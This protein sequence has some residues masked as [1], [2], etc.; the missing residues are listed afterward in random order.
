[1]TEENRRQEVRHKIK[2]NVAVVTSE[3]QSASAVATEISTDGM[4][5]ETAKVMLP[6]TQVAIFLQLQDEIQLRGTIMWTLGYLAKGLTMYQIGIKTE[7][8][9]RPD[10]ASIEH[11]DKDDLVQ[12]VLLA[13]KMQDEAE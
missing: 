7:A 6:G 9:V 8:I 5:I 10:V 3:A 11:T 1:M 4:R 12:D 2:V 13:A